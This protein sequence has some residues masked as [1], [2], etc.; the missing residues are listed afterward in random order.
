META[1]GLEFDPRLQPLGDQ[2]RPPAA[3]SQSKVGK[4]ETLRE[5]A[6]LADT[7]AIRP[8]TAM[9]GRGPTDAT[10]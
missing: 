10:P 5:D 8:R 2:L 6:G 4:M 7:R 3:L 9:A 1:G